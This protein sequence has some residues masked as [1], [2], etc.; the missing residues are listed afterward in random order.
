MLFPT[1]CSASR[2][3]VPVGCRKKERRKEKRGA[4]HDFLRC[5]EETVNNVCFLFPRDLFQNVRKSP[6][7]SP[8]ESTDFTLNRAACRQ[9]DISSTS[10]DGTVTG[11]YTM[12][13]KTGDRNHSVNGLRCIFLSDCYEGKESRTSQNLLLRS[14][15]GALPPSRMMCGWIV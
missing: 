5:N 15:T 14:R 6:L 2:G 8:A 11:G 3:S 9:E 7:H 13:A 12:E 1:T 4:F 10:A